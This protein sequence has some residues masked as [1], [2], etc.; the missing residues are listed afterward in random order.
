MPLNYFYLLQKKRLSILG[1]GGTTISQDSVATYLEWGT[2][3]SDHLVANVESF[4]GHGVKINV[5]LSLQCQISRWIICLGY[6]CR[7]S[8]PHISNYHLMLLLLLLSC[9][10]WLLVKSVFFVRRLAL[11]DTSYSSNGVLVLEL[12]YASARY[13]RVYM[14]GYLRLFNVFLAFD[15]S[16][17]SVI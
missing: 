9:L 4:Q 13:K 1:G 15:T 12:N 6:V 5:T 16:I 17:L 2:I 7:H 10:V 3:S 11:V 8:C 14:E